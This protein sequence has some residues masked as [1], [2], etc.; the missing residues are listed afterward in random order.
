MWLSDRSGLS[1]ALLAS[2]ALVEEAGSAQTGQVAV[3]AGETQGEEEE[4]HWQDEEEDDQQGHT[5]RVRSILE[6][7]KKLEVLVIMAD[8][9]LKLGA[10]YLF[11]PTFIDTVSQFLKDLIKIRSVN[12]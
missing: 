9:E 4:N 2:G 5:C 7:Q 12:L 6:I 1:P 8:I 11:H 3:T 10:C